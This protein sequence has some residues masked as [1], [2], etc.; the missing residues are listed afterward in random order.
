MR[1]IILSAGLG[2]R[3][4][5][6]TKNT[7]K[8]LMDIGGITI[9][10]NQ[11]RTLNEGGIKDISIVIGGKGEC[12]TKENQNIIKKIIK[13]VIIN[14]ENTST[15][16]S[17][18][19]R[20]AL[21]NSSLDNLF[22]I[23]GDAYFPVDLVKKIILDSRNVIISKNEK[24]SPGNKL[25]LGKD[26]KV[27]SL[28]RT[29]P[30]N[31]VYSGMFKINKEE[32]ENFKYLVCDPEFYE[33]DLGFLLDK[34][35]KE[36]E[37]FNMDYPKWININTAEELETV[38]K[39]VGRRFLAIMFGYTAAGKSTFAQKISR[40]PNTEIFHSAVVRKELGLSPKTKEE[41]D[42]FF[43]YQN[44]LR[45]EVDK[46]VYTKLS[47]LARNS[48]KNNKNAVLDAGFFFSWQ[49][50]LI[51]KTLSELNPELFVVK[52]I[53]K[54]EAEIKRRLK[55]RGKNFKASPLNETPS[56]NTYVATKEM[57][58]PLEKD[59][60]PDKI[61]LFVLEYDTLKNTIKQTYGKKESINLKKIMEMIK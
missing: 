51:Y 17:Y 12:W 35:C 40:I 7:P 36:N 27:M 54:D 20:L 49:R 24:N 48:L 60:I 59:K 30:S 39:L 44:N 61:K 31:M 5:D 9:L 6:L 10:E 38:R 46:K 37:L 23:D 52:V 2:T 43:D 41:A 45:Q 57:T 21:K 58:E 33:K 53:C 50:E 8:C 25:I 13:N 14:E 47:E 29:N 26:G 22:I 56:W 18:S 3:L 32:F 1:A 55:I 4:G 28:T 19:L 34:F 42:K 16:N 15:N 11:I